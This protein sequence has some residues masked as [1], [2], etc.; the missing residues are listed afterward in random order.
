MPK[1]SI[2]DKV[3]HQCNKWYAIFESAICIHVSC[4]SDVASCY[5]CAQRLVNVACRTIKCGTIVVRQGSSLETAFKTLEVQQR[6]RKGVYVINIC[7]SEYVR[8]IRTCRSAEMIRCYDIDM[9]F[10]RASR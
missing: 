1:D 5:T 2:I 7:I 6:S 10:Q 4:K 9:V 8:A 3:L